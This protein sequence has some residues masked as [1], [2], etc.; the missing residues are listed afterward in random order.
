M[1][2]DEE[3]RPASLQSTHPVV[4]GLSLGARLALGFGLIALLF[5]IANYLSQRNATLVTQRIDENTKISNELSSTA[6]T[7]TDA[8]AGY[9]RVV[10]DIDGSSANAEA[11]KALSEADAALTQAVKQYEALENRVAESLTAEDLNTAVQALQTNARALI[12]EASKSGEPLSRYWANFDRLQRELVNLENSGWR[13]GDRIVTHRSTTAIVDALLD[14]RRVVSAY[15]AAPNTQRASRISIQ[16]RE[17][18]SILDANVEPLVKMRSEDWLNK[19]RADFERLRQGLRAIGVAKDRLEKRVVSVA[20]NIQELASTVRMGIGEPA[21]KMLAASAIEAGEIVQQT[22]RHMKMTSIAILAL[23]VAIAFF[24]VASV[25][26]PITRLI[27]A[28]R[29]LAG[30][31]EAARAARGG[32]RELDQL[33]SAF[34][35]MA[36]RLSEAQRTMRSDQI[37][38]EERVIER[39]Q[40]LQHLAY[41]DTLTQL[42]NRRHLFQHLTGLLDRA[43]GAHNRVA[44]L[45]LDIDNFKVLNDSLG[46]LF[47]D[48]VLKAVSERLVEAIGPD[49]FVAR[50]GGDE[51]TIVCEHSA[52]VAGQAEAL[53]STFQTPLHVDDREII[54][55]VSIGAGVFPEHA[56]DAESLLRAADAALFK[57]KEL[58][59]NRTCVASTDLIERIG[60]QFKTEQALRRATACNELLLVFQ[61]QLNLSQGKVNIVEA[62]VRWKR[63]DALV[64]PVDFLPLAEQSGLI[65]EITDWVLRSAIATLAEWRRGAWPQARIAVN[66]SAQQ[67][68]DRTF[69]DKLRVM[70]DEHNVP[71]SSLEL[72]LTETALQSGSATVNALRALR[73]LGVGIALDDFG[74][75]YSSLASLEQLSLSRVKIDRSL[76]AHVD[77]DPR[78]TS[79]ARSIIDLCRSLNLEVTIEGIEHQEQFHFLRNCENVDV[80][81]YLFAHPLPADAVLDACNALP[82]RLLQ[83]KADDESAN[84]AQQATAASILPWRGPQRIR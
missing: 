74:A 58:G 21:A 8:L 65:A 14:V 35:E 18:S 39:T 26:G 54:V 46:H 15:L 4:R 61:P 81:G 79:I 19:I 64:S 10:L 67:L 82:L 37:R 28:T 63:S 76:I 9:Q 32:A 49:G 16:E 40:Q 51:F 62:L 30:G 72:E 34:N 6:R 13:F 23:I 73:Q 56:S 71:P 60:G 38:L 24:T 17:F 33:A 55:S 84:R 83:L 53:V 11:I 52:A 41:H 12:N 77:R 3:I 59:R 36:G 29:R 69:V 20:S 31:D 27:H 1:V 50:L 45:L 80:Q 44:L 78:S 75:G 57:A 5:L 22:N 25:T 7:L 68:M 2:S 66:V 47:G 43:R 70:L 42:P 48:R